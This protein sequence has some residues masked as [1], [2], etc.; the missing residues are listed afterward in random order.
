VTLAPKLVG[1]SLAGES[2][3]SATDRTTTTAASG[4]S[5]KKNRVVLGTKRK[6][7]R[8]SADQ[9]IIELPSYYGPQSPL[10]LVA[11]EHTFGRLFEAF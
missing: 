5:Q 7:D 2:R 11:V 9:V 8:A 3:P 4:G 1:S 10:D 6:P